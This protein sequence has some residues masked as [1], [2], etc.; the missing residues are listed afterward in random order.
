MKSDGCRTG[1]PED[2]GPDFG[3]TAALLGLTK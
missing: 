1:R 3:L 2:F